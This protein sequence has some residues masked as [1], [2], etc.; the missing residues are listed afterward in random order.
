MSDEI[1][2]SIIGSSVVLIGIVWNGCLSRQKSNELLINSARQNQ[3]NI[4]NESLIRLQTK[5]NEFYYPIKIYLEK[6]KNIY[7]VFKVDKPDNFRTL[8]YLLDKEQLYEGIPY[9]LNINDRA[10]LKQIFEIGVEIERIMAEKGTLIDDPALIEPY[11]PSEEF[12]GDDVGFPYPETKSLLSIAQLHLRFIRLA[13]D[14]EIVG[15]SDNLSPY[16]FPR[17]LNNI[18]ENKIV[19]LKRKIADVKEQQ[20]ILI[21]KMRMKIGD[22]G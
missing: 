4:L 1:I 17:E 10:F 8:T 3:Y 12:I 18:I 22:E 16:V 14:G 13:F 15:N 21:V 11:S 5:L 9:Q 19:E 7:D 20:G 6:S 2:V